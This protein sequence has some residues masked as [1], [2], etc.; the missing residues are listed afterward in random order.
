MISKSLTT[1][2]VARLCRVSNATVKR[3]EDAGL[4]NSERTSGGHRRFRAEEVARF[5]REQNLGLKL[6]H[7]DESV[8][9]AGARRTE[10]GN[11]S[12]SSLFHSLVAGAEAEAANGLIAAHLHG[13]PLTDIFDDLICPAM[14]R[15]GEL[16]YKGELSIA[17]EHLATRTA[18]YAIHTL[19]RVLTVPEMTGE[20]AMCCGIEGDFHD[21]PSHLAQMTIENEGWEVLN[22]GANMPLHSLTEEVLR[23]SPELICVS[24][25]LIPDIERISRDY[26]DFR[27]RIGKLKI[28]VIVGG[29]AFSDGQIRNRFPAE[30]YAESFK[31]VAGFVR[32]IPRK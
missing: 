32:N 4:I 18:Q 30:F 31:D 24:A 16:W 10:N 11:H 13:N 20:L 22:F 7:G 3:W 26:K 17:Q 6:K 5:Q 2:E 1:R 14:N 9:R 12:D 15:V 21:L 27:E 19:R 8:V 29:R 23:H 28:P 25:T